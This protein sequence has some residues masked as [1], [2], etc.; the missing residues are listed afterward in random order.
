[1]IDLQKVAFTSLYNTEK[2]VKVFDGSFQYGIDTV[3]R[4]FDFATMEI[5]QIPHGFTR[6]VYTELFWSL[7]DV[8][9]FV[10]GGLPDLDDTA[11]LISY[12]DSTNVCI[13]T[14]P[15]MSIPDGTVI[16]YKIVCGWIN[17]YDNT[18]PQ[19]EAFQDF[20][21]N[22]KI[23]FNSRYQTSMI[24]KE[25]K[26]TLETTSSSFTDVFGSENHDLGYTPI[27]KCYFNAFPGEVWPLN[28]GG[29]KNPY[30]VDFTDQVEA[31]AF[32]DGTNF[33]VDAVMKNL[34][35]EVNFWYMLYT[36]V[37]TLLT[38]SNSGVDVGI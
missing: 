18:D 3:E 4:A 10:G 11:Y 37:D 23:N 13:M 8:N 34:S 35:G 38:V 27:M 15:A 9:Y 36:P 20:P 22:Y 31:Q 29:V 24:A 19:I 16:Y 26:I 12:S 21:D 2:I 30:L 28:Y 25:G 6:P 33:T 7:D 14:I 1:M 17:D 5:F 32:V